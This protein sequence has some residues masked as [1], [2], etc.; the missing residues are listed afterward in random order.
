M[1]TLTLKLSQI[2]VNLL[3]KL[4]RITNQ[5]T[6][7]GC[8]RQL[9]KKYE[10]KQNRIYELERQL[11][12]TEHELEQIKYTSKEYFQSMHELMRESGFEQKL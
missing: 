5:K 7:T 2:E 12:R 1:S 9:I 3:D 6:S 11:S 10:I 8:I 4:K